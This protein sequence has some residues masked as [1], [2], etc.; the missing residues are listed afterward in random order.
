MKRQKTLTKKERKAL[1]GPGPSGH[2][3]QHIHCIA[4]GKHLDH[5]QFHSGTA[6]WLT[7]QHGSRFAACTECSAH[8]ERLLAEHDRTGRPV[9]QAAAWH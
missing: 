6:T 8:G 4:C 7:C 5:E 3:H 1:N 9:A 2:E